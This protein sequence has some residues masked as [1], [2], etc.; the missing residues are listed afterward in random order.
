MP[1]P[2]LCWQC[3]SVTVSGLSLTSFVAAIHQV[4]RET[5]FGFTAVSFRETHQPLAVITATLCE[6]RPLRK[7]LLYY[8]LWLVF[9]YTHQSVR[10]CLPAYDNHWAMTRQDCK[11]GFYHSKPNQTKQTK[12]KNSPNRLFLIYLR[13]CIHLCHIA[14]GSCQCSCSFGWGKQFLWHPSSQGLLGAVYF[15]K[16]YWY[17]LAA[18]AKLSLASATLEQAC[19]ANSQKT[20][21]QDLASWP[22]DTCQMQNVCPAHLCWDRV[23]IAN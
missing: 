1:Y 4:A 22:T 2:Q 13:C 8:T 3:V 6:P 7:P 17:K 14:N 5:Y 23:N 15:S 16:M 9:Q 21:S 12:L 10:P 19:I 20:S 18:N 11:L